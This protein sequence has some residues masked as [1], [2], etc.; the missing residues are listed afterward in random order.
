MTLPT[1]GEI[2]F[3]MIEDEFGGE[4]PISLSEYYARAAGIPASGEIST[5]D[6]YGTSNYTAPSATGGTT[7]TSGGYKYHKFTSSGSF[8][9]SN[10]G[11]SGAIDF[12]F[13]AGG[14]AGG[15]NQGGGGGGG[16]YRF[17]STTVSAQS[18]PIA[19]GA[20]GTAG[21]GYSS[22]GNV[23]SNSTGI[24]QTA[25]GGGGGGGNDNSIGGGSSGGS[26]G[27]AGRRGYPGG[28]GTQGN[29]GGGNNNTYNSGCGG[30]GAGATGGT[31]TAARAGDGGNGRRELT[32]ANATSSGE[33]SGYYCGGGGAGAHGD[34][35]GVGGN[36][37]LGG[38][39][40][41]S[42]NGTNNGSANTGGGG[43][44]AGNPYTG[45]LG[46]SGIVLIRYAI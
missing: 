5:D 36:G 41:G 45:G 32:W 3:Q 40:T 21:S 4:H 17:A 6:F 12:F 43:D 46:G 33:D 28:S 1:S 19:V 11:S 34:H 37:G 15:S 35:T 2:T 25:N 22:R 44:G 24:G 18:Y 8:A 27:G 38:G 29:A 14:G 10:A 16:G 13:I 39:A 23:G 7:Y 20:G 26:G 42:T 9:V 31:P 30:G